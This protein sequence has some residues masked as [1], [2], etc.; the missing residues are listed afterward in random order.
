MK[1]K[2]EMAAKMVQILGTRQFEEWHATKFEEYICGENNISKSE[3]I[4]NFAEIF[5]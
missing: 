1:T 5:L 4:N 2:M 3:I